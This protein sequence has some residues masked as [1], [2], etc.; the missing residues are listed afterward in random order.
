MS[1]SFSVWQLA[2]LCGNTTQQVL[3]TNDCGGGEECAPF[4]PQSAVSA[5]SRLSAA[6]SC[7]GVSSAL[8]PARVRKTDDGLWWIQLLK[9]W[10]WRSGGRARDGQ[11]WR[12]C[13]RARL[14]Y[15]R[16]VCYINGSS[17]VVSFTSVVYSR[18]GDSITYRTNWNFK[19]GSKCAYFAQLIP[20]THVYNPGTRER[21]KCRPC[22]GHRHRSRQGR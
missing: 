11:S 10:Q 17:P 12:R 19:G 3:I 1:L 2:Q 22:I 15:T 7:V 13:S 21:V 8:P 14:L 18:H 9:T 6:A 20:F 5:N 4:L 16:L